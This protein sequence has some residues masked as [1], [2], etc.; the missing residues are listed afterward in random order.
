MSDDAKEVLQDMAGIATTEF[1]FDADDDVN[2]ESLTEL[3]EFVRAGAML[4]HA[5]LS[6]A[7]RPANDT[8]H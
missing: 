7:S 6:R 2:D 3:E 1:E 8:L 5:E 4:L